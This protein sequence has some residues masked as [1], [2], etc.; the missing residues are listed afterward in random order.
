MEG[1]P[2]LLHRGQLKNSAL[3][4]IVPEQSETHFGPS[5]SGSFVA[6]F[7]SSQRIYE[8]IY[9]NTCATCCC[10]HLAQVL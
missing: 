2:A 6:T 5:C 7:I 10:I 8:L 1:E 9:R 4:S 3:L